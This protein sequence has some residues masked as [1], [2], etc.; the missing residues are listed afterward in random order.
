MGTQPVAEG[1][2]REGVKQSLTE[3]CSTY[4]V[5]ECFIPS[6]L[7]AGCDEISSTDYGKGGVGLSFLD[8]EVPVFL[9]NVTCSFSNSEDSICGVFQ[10][11]TKMVGPEMLFE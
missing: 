6:A 11:F 8:C 4:A 1:W 9:Q 2:S 7:P 3:L 5:F 10:A